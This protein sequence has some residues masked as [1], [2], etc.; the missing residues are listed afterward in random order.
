[1]APRRG[2]VKADRLDNERLALP[3]ADRGAV[4]LR[5][6][7]V[8]HRPAVRRDDARVAHLALNQ[9]EAGALEYLQVAVVAERE[10]W[11][12]HAGPHDAALG[13]RAELRPVELAAAARGLA[14]VAPR[15]GL[16]QQRRDP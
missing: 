2:G 5:K 9:D 10:V 8:R 15:D 14:R 1:A 13:Q 7:V 4:P 16:R 11:R 6:Q 3:A 12:Q